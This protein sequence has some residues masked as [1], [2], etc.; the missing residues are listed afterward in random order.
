MQRTPLAADGAYLGY[1]LFPKEGDG[2]FVL[3]N[4]KTGKEW[5]EPIGARP[6]VAP[7]NRALQNP[8]DPPPAPP[9]IVVAF[10]KDSRTVVFSTFPPKSEIDQAHKEKKKPEEMPKNGIVILD[11]DSGKT[12]R[13]AR[14]K[15]FQV[16]EEG[17]GFMA[18]LKLRDDEI[19]K[20]ARREKRNVGY[21]GERV[22]R[23]LSDS[24]ERPCS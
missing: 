24:S 10:S 4:L 16:P 22:L 20:P 7:P 17:D 23:K 13:V 14:V 19:T 9:S 5:G 12:E 2:K 21:G 3:R 6:P 18:Y 15:S 11:I 8:D 1:A